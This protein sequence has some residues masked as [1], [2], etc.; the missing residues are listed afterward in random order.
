MEHRFSIRP[1]TEAV[2]NA[3]SVWR[4]PENLSFYDGE[5][6]TDEL[7]NGE[8][9]EVYEGDELIGFYCFGSSACVNGYPYDGYAIDYGLGLKPEKV[10]KGLGRAFVEYG[11]ECAER[12]YPGREIRLT[13]ACFNEV[14]A[15]LYASLGFEVE[16]RFTAA[17]GTPFAVMRRRNR[18]FI[19]ISRPLREGMQVYS[20]HEEFKKTQTRTIEKDKYNLTHFSMGAH[21]GTHMDAPTHFLENAETI[22]EIPLNLLTGPV[23]INTMRDGESYANL[24]YGTKRLI[25]RSSDYSGMSLEEA[26]EIIRKGVRLIGTDRLSVAKD[27]FDMVVHKKLLGAGVWILETLALDAAEDGYYTLHCL[28]L[29]IVG[30]EGAPA[31]VLLERYA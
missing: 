18:R 19:D 25:V 5:G 17:S 6:A 15:R 2:A 9:H 21:C 27:G 23:L 14:A 30:A 10:G 1:M 11:I 16:G 12:A 24:P 28:P 22:D 31:R 8:Y 29:N 20:G 4:Y 7:L 3:L 13:V 26:D